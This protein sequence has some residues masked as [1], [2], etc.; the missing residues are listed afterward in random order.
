MGGKKQEEI[1]HRIQT[2]EHFEEIIAEGNNKVSVIDLHLEWCGPCMVIEPNFRALYFQI[3]NAPERV[4]FWTA[5]E[6][7]IPEHIIKTL[8]KGPLSS[9]PRFLIW[10][11]GK[12]AAE[13]DGCLLTD[14]EAK[15][16]E[17]MPQLD[18]V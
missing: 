17:V 9:K 2:M 14:I 11:Q 3:D 18:D 15:V 4:E 8:A 6:D 1:V 16:F 10:H 7:I 5:C 13:I 12:K